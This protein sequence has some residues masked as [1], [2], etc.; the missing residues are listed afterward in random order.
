MFA[1]SFEVEV[2]DHL[3]KATHFTKPADDPDMQSM[4][5]PARTLQQMRCTLRLPLS[6]GCHERNLRFEIVKHR[7]VKTKYW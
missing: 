7:T 6:W 3:D 2:V 4:N 5:L 1:R